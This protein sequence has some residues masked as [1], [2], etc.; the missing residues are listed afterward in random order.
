MAE[1][2]PP[3]PPPSSPTCVQPAALCQDTFE[4]HKP[5]VQTLLIIPPLQA[6]VRSREFSMGRVI[7]IQAGCQLNKS[8][9]VIG[10]VQ[11]FSVAVNEGLEQRLV[12][13]DGLQY[14]SI[15]GHIAD[16]PLSQARATEPKD[17]TVA[18][19]EDNTFHCSA[20]P[21]KPDKWQFSENKT[22]L[23]AATI[24]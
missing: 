18:G 12:V 5:E 8:H 6:S 24:E 15:A 7:N 9:C 10:Y 16:G 13:G 23:G 14:V 1:K 2:P 11:A 20:L 3:V 22:N 17:V 21:R 4:V 19:R